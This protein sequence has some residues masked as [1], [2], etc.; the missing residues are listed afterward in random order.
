MGD[1]W[2]R[3]SY[4]ICYKLDVLCY[5]RLLSNVF[6]ISFRE[7]KLTRILQESLGGRTKT[8]IIATISPGHKDLEETMSTLE[9][10][11]RARNIQNKPEINQKLT[12][13]AILKDFAEEIDKL[14]RELSAT[15]EKNGK[16]IYVFLN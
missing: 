15:R 5:P 1:V 11:H 6:L 8:S 14:K 4:V 16:I 10:A 7:S 2:I 13:Q 12:K 3:Y 9:Y